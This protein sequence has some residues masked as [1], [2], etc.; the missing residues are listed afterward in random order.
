MLIWTPTPTHRLTSSLGCRAALSLQDSH[1][2]LVT[3]TGPALR[4]FTA[5][6]HCAGQGSALPVPLPAWLRL[7]CSGTASTPATPQQRPG[8]FINNGFACETT[9]SFQR[10]QTDP[11]WAAKLN[12]ST[13]AFIGFLDA[14]G[15]TGSQLI[16][17][18]RA[19]THGGGQDPSET[20]QRAGRGSPG[21]HGGCQCGSSADPCEG[22]LFCGQPKQA[23]TSNTRG[24]PVTLIMAA[25]I[26]Y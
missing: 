22:L 26:N 25:D 9:I 2:H 14:W 21:V 15:N 4:L 5:G 19:E 13:G 18:I 6:L 24:F 10:R 3:V 12:F 17:L 8:G 16:Q 1:A 20:W 23:G 7:P 11:S